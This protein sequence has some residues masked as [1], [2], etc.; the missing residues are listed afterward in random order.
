MFDQ[1]SFL[2]GFIFCDKSKSEGDG[3]QS[4]FKS[5]IYGKGFALELSIMKTYSFSF[6]KIRT[7][8]W[9][10]FVLSFS[11]IFSPLIGHSLTIQL[12]RNINVRVTEN[13]SH[14]ATR[15]SSRGTLKRVGVLKSGTKIQIP[16]EFVEKDPKGKVDFESTLNRWLSQSH[17]TGDSTDTGLP[18]LY[19]FNGQKQ[20]YFFPVTLS[21]KNKGNLDLSNSD[22]DKPLYVALSFLARNKNQFHIIEDVEVVEGQEVVEPDTA[23]LHPASTAPQSESEAGKCHEKCHFQQREDNSPA[24][25]DNSALVRLISALS[26]TLDKVNSKTKSFLPNVD[27]DKHRVQLDRNL[28]RTCGPAITMISLNAEIETEKKQYQNLSTLS[29]ND[30]LSMM[31][32]ESSGKCDAIKKENNSESI[33]LFQINTKSATKGISSCNTAQMAQ[34]RG[35]QSIQDLKENRSLQC[36]QNPMV[37][38]RE[39]LRLLNGKVKSLNKFSFQ[40]MT[41]EDQRRLILSAYNGGEKWVERARTDLEV[42]NR[43]NETNLSINKWEDLRLFYLRR[44]LDDN[45]QRNLFG[46]VHDRDE[47]RTL[48]NTISNLAYVE[49]LVPRSLPK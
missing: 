34:I 3:D 16:K 12:N 5:L 38:L 20:D 36:L 17:F 42:F 39:S 25:A 2:M 8:R 27:I 24:V 10:S 30:I 9:L 45:N 32:K 35:T 19:T 13:T 7:K 26:A 21:D 41:S 1:V 43:R 15:P 48:N 49:A 37:S 14:V 44:A 22:K 29:S 46:L 47:Q 31:M 23:G 33:G 6:L 28:S 11:L 4:L 18:G 40:T